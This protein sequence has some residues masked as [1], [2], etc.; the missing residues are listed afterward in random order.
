MASVSALDTVMRLGF[1][2]RGIAYLV[3]GLALLAAGQAAD[4]ALLLSGLGD[5][6]TGRGGLLLVGL[7]LFGYGVLGWTSSMLRLDGPAIRLSR[8]LSGVLHAAVA[9][10]AIF[11][12]SGGANAAE[13]LISHLSGD[14]RIATA[15]G[16]LL[17]AAGLW[18]LAVVWHAS[19]LRHLLP[20]ARR[21]AWL[22][23]GGRAAYLGRGLA[24]LLGGLFLWNVHIAGPEETLRA[25]GG[26]LNL[27]AL[28]LILFGLFSLIEAAYARFAPAEG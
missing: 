27:T 20:A 15:I 11:L 28:G 4:P 16:A 22:A 25:T 12:A 17:A 18:Q 1:A 10:Y 13:R 7:G 3:A 6:W 5:A 24:F 2:G 26:E 9:L 23:W 19:F 8:F 14:G 21:A